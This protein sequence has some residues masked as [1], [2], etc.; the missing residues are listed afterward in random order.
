[1]AGINEDQVLEYLDGLTVLQISE[2][3]SKLE[4]RWGVSAHGSTR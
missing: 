1:M 4:E 3:V 2:L